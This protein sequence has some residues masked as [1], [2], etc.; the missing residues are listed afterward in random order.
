MKT[1]LDDKVR[2]FDAKYICLATQTNTNVLKTLYTDKDLKVQKLGSLLN[3]TKP[4]M[5]H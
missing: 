3:T 1:A 5:K 4:L 2:R